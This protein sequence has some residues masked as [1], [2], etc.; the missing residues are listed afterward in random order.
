MGAST[1]ACRVRNVIRSSVRPGPT[2]VLPSKAHT[3]CLQRRQ[4][5]APPDTACGRHAME[6]ELEPRSGGV[7]LR[8]YSVVLDHEKPNSRHWPKVSQ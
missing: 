1:H 2:E 8:R 3:A 5:A 6:L 7:R 4:P